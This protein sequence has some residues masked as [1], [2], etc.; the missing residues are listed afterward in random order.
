[1]G[2]ITE[3]AVWEDNVLQ[4]EVGDAVGG[5]AQAVV[6]LQAQDLANRT[7][8]L[9]QRTD[10]LES[11]TGGKSNLFATAQ[12]TTADDITQGYTV[13]SIWYYNGTYYRCTDATTGAAVWAT[14]SGYEGGKPDKP[15]IISPVNSAT[16]VVIFMPKI[17]VSGYKNDLG[18][19]CGG[20][21]VVVTRNSDSVVVADSGWIS[22]GAYKVPLVLDINTAYKVKARYKCVYGDTSDY[23]DEF[24]FTTETKFVV[25]RAQDGDDI[26][27][28]SLIDSEG[29]YI[30]EGKCDFEWLMG[31]CPTLRN[32]NV[33]IVDGQSMI[34]FPLFFA[35]AVVAE[36]G[37]AAGK[38]C[39]W[40]SPETETGFERHYAFH[41]P[42]NGALLSNV[43]LGMYE[44]STDASVSSKA[45]SVINSSPK[46]SITNA[47]MKNMCAA[48]NT[49]GVTG[50]LMPT[51]YMYDMVKLL[52]LIAYG[53]TDLQHVIGMGNVGN[54]GEAA[55][56]VTS[57]RSDAILFGLRE[58]WGNVWEWSDITHI[59]TTTGGAIYVTK[60]GTAGTK[61]SLGVKGCS[62]A[63][64]VQY[65]KTF[66]STVVNGINLAL[67]F[68]PDEATNVTD[69]AQ[70]AVPD[71][72]YNG[73][74]S[75]HLC[76]HGGCLASGMVAGPWTRDFTGSATGAGWGNGFRLARIVAA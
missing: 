42:A 52:A 68:I 73:G 48:R 46:C 74:E 70:A 8:Y 35:K 57:G 14:Q 16:G 6:N 17:L 50:F 12:P 25:G 72:Q 61:V 3:S 76:Y 2:N 9:K 13:G 21:Q 27:T 38:L 29:N 47:A 69:I 45:A 5:G 60:P 40:I 53:S 24:T 26:S 37:D 19:P 28:W 66:K 56:I 65:P 59:T 41:N 58:F 10:I 18:L 67:L 51:G 49:G 1:M 75:G 34:D 30:D 20:M 15:K 71:Y 44:A 23:S 63:A 36:T 7:K 62:V 31:A 11:V 22:E 4:I 64:Q 54:A 43:Q 33:V 32:I 39:Y 55:K